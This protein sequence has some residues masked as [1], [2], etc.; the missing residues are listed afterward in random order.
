MTL[1]AFAATEFNNV[2]PGREPH[3]GVKNV[4]HFR[5]WL[6][7]HHQGVDD[8]CFGSTKPSATPWWWGWIQSLQLWMPFTPGHGCLPE[9]FYW[10]I[11]NYLSWWVQSPDYSKISEVLHVEV[12]VT[13]Q[14]LHNYFWKNPR[15]A[16]FYRFIDTGGQ[17]YSVT[18]QSL[19][20]L[21][22]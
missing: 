21:I 5:E 3:Q 19:D 14:I 18:G 8:G 13:C 6:R 20:D 4:R 9:K 17:D 11:N 2:F 7:P 15:N 22:W 10:M 1:E 12:P 16:H